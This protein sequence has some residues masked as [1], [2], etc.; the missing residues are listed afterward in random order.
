MLVANGARE[1]HSRAN[2][3]ES[4]ARHD[5]QLLLLARKEFFLISRSLALPVNDLLL[6][7][8]MG[9]ICIVVGTMLYFNTIKIK[10]LMGAEELEELDKSLLDAQA[11]ELKEVGGW[12]QE[13]EMQAQI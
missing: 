2:E 6:P 8:P 12:E 5:F 11:R 4:G 9:F 3:N 1:W 7:Q 10:A 13:R